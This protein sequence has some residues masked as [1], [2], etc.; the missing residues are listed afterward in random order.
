M[1]PGDAIRAGGSHLVVAR[2]IVAAQDPKA[3]A[4]SI[5]DEMAAA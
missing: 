1:T 2:P 3:A 5:L 4:Q